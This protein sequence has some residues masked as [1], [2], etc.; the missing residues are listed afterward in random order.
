MPDTVDA[1]TRLLETLAAGASPADL[2]ALDVD[3][4][5]RD[6]AMR[7]AGAFDVQRRREQ[8]L[9]ALVDTARELASMTDPS[10]VLLNLFR[11]DTGEP[12]FLG[13]TPLSADLT[14]FAGQVVR[15]RI[16]VAAYA[17]PLFAAVDDVRLTS[18]GTAPTAAVTGGTGEW[19]GATG[20]VTI[21]DRSTEQETGSLYEADVV[22]PHR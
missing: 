10:V 18:S 1:G 8:Q 2:A 6:L 4:H 5:A 9:A 12:Q 16:A 15:L 17:N 20:A 22:L 13:P 14:P 3:P 11:T 19:F 7:I 21:T